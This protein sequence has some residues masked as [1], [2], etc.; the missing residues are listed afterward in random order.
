MI[1]ADRAKEGYVRT[2]Y[3]PLY[4]AG[5]VEVSQSN[6]PTWYEKDLDAAP[7]SKLK[8]RLTVKAAR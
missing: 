3:P 5:Q 8:Q 7:N 4:S 1:R 2:R 6:A